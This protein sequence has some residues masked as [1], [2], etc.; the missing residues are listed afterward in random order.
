[1]V[2]YKYIIL[3][4]KIISIK[5]YLKKKLEELKYLYKYYKTIKNH[6]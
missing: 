3:I 4:F 5:E 6:L 1:M 2:S